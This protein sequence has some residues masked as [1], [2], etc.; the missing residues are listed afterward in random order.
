MGVDV[1]S[2]LKCGYCLIKLLFKLM[3]IN[4]IIV[5]AHIGGDE[6]LYQFVNT[7]RILNY[8]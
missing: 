1:H 2:I 7:S 6:I 8:F 3:L 4:N 5:P